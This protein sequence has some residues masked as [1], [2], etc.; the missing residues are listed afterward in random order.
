MTI[1]AA[2]FVILFLH[3]YCTGV[4]IPVVRISF[5]ATKWSYTS[6]TPN[7]IE[8]VMGVHAKTIL[9]SLNTAFLSI[10]RSRLKQLLLA[11]LC[12]FLGDFRAFW[13]RDIFFSKPDSFNWGKYETNLGLSFRGVNCTVVLP[14]HLNPNNYLLI[15]LQ[16]SLLFMCHFHLHLSP[17]AKMA[18][19]AFTCAF[20]QF[21]SSAAV[22]T[23]FQDCHPALELSFSTVHLQVNCFW[24]A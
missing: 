8:N 5:F 7:A 15:L 9:T 22:H 24:A 4:F 12:K 23:S 10:S 17:G 11:V 1:L 19:K 18:H 21:L 2:V 20:H 13:E 14:I 16:I 3:S 6:V